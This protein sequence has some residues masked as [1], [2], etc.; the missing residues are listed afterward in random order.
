MKENLLI[1]AAIFLVMTFI[2]CAEV[3]SSS[4]QVLD[5]AN[6]VVRSGSK[7]LWNTPT[8]EA[9]TNDQVEDIDSKRY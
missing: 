2:A 3:T 4:S 7:N 1:I 5:N 9:R 8:P 6:S